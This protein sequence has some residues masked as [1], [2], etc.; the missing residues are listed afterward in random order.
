MGEKGVLVIITQAT[1]KTKVNQTS[2][3]SREN[4]LYAREEK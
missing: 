4:K 2:V 1:K 3:E